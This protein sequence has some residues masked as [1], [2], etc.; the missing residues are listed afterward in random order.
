[1]YDEEKQV[2]WDDKTRKYLNSYEIY[3]LLNEKDAE[4]KRLMNIKE[5]NEKK[6]L[7]K[8]I[9]ICR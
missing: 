8:R 3:N 9:F 4:I 1:M 2:V 7:N 6:F 5:Y